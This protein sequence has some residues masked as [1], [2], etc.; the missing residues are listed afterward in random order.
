M[1]II[2]LILLGWV[3]VILLIIS[4][5]DTKQWGFYKQERIGKKSKVFKI[6]KIRT[7]TNQY[8]S[9]GYITTILDSRITPIGKKIRK[10]KLDELPQLINIIVGDMSFVGPR[11]DVKGYA[12]ELKGDDRVILSVKP[13]ITSSASLKYRNEEVILSKVENPKKYNDEVIWP[14][15]I[16]MNKEYVLNWSFKKDLIILYKTLFK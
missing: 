14:D 2:L 4:F 7:M 15:K 16:R 11:P 13:G 12:D 10:Y 3:I 9:E 5:Y 8:E 6:F 1:A